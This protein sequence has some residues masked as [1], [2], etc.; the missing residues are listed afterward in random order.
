M[1]ADDRAALVEMA[2]SS[3]AESALREPPNAPNG[4]RFA[5]TMK[6]DDMLMKWLILRLKLKPCRC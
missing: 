5:A 4:V 3:V 2:P 1:L 6:M